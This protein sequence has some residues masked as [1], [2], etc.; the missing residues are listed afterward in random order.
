MR[1]TYSLC[2]IVDDYRAV[3]ISIVHRRQRLVSFLSSRVPDLKFDS[4]VLVQG[5]CLRQE[6]GADCGFSVVV[7]L[8]LRAKRLSEYSSSFRIC[9][10]KPIYLYESENKRTLLY[11]LVSP[12]TTSH[13]QL[14]YLANS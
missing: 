8:V 7:E 2:D 6:G 3:C 14:L 10:K 11:M 4:G 9:R 5:Y 1:S 12:A 13:T